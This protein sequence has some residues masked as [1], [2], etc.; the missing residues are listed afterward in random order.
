MALGKRQ[1]IVFALAAVVALTGVVMSRGEKPARAPI[2][3]ND[4]A[5]DMVREMRLL[6]QEVADGIRPSLPST[7]E[8]GSITLVDVQA[9]P[10]LGMAYSYRVERV[11]DEAARAHFLRETPRLVAEQACAVPEI[12]DYMEYGTVYRYSYTDREGGELLSF[13]LDEAACRRHEAG[14]PAIIQ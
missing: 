2:A 13:D 11:L 7:A 14:Q 9:G 10:H 12:R 6:F 8:D 4:P 5:A 1:V 3:V